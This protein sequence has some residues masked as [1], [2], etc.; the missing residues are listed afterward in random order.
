[1]EL[2]QLLKELS[3]IPFFF[4]YLILLRMDANIISTQV[5]SQPLKN[6]GLTCSSIVKTLSKLSRDNC[7]NYCEMCF[8]DPSM[9]PDTDLL[10]V[11]FVLLSGY[12]LFL[13][14]RSSI[15]CPLK[16]CPSLSVRYR[17]FQTFPPYAS[18]FS[19]V[20]E[21]G[22]NRLTF[23]VQSVL[24]NIVIPKT[25]PYCPPE[26]SSCLCQDPVIDIS[27]VHLLFF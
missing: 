24:R 11:W 3:I 9:S 20:K 18:G 5:F 13:I 27:S 21:N 25:L 14:C 15:T 22:A 12:F 6:V 4:F 8:E 26:T 10:P 7:R 2:I 16:E 19:S 23:K 1:M 17:D